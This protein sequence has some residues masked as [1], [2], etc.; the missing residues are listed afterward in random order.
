M[1][2]A[3][4]ERLRCTKR[5]SDGNSPRPANADHDHDPHDPRRREPFDGR[6]HYCSHANLVR[7]ARHAN[8]RRDRPRAI[9]D[10]LRLRYGRS[11]LPS[12]QLL[13][14]PIDRHHNRHHNSGPDNVLQRWRY[15]DGLPDG[16]LR[17]SRHPRRRMLPHG[18]KLP[19]VL[20]P[21]VDPLNSRLGWQDHCGGGNGHRR[22][23]RELCDVY[24]RQ[25]VVHVRIQRRSCGWMLS[26]RV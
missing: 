20:L 26:E 22:S 7:Q 16:V 21:P 17:L 4:E 12:D 13:D 19:D 8:H 1:N 9:L 3:N 24:M 11:S 14:I 5:C 10:Q 25:W 6:R 23:S 2:K 15:P 18:S